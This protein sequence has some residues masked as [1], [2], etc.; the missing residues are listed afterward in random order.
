[1]SDLAVGFGLVLV[2]EGLLWAAAPETAMRMLAT[3]AAT[4]VQQLRIAG[5]FATAL[6]VL[7]VWLIRG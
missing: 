3:A 2:F 5:A 1:M 6:G 4:P 7:V